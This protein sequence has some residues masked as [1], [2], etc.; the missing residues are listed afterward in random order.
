M[1]PEFGQAWPKTSS[2]CVEG[3]IIE[4]FLLT[5]FAEWFLV[6]QC[7]DFLLSEA[8]GVKFI[9]EGDEEIWGRS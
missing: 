1:T 9:L 7:G 5:S 3:W 4:S 2:V 6:C 8:N